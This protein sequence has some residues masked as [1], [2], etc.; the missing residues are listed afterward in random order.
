MGL[1][2]AK[3]PSSL[4]DFSSASYAARNQN[5]PTTVAKVPLI[6]NEA[7]LTLCPCIYKLTCSME[8]MLVGAR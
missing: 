8:N 5:M 6:L 3:H 4:V 2:G 7:T 1:L